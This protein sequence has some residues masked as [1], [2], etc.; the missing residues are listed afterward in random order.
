MDPKKTGNRAGN[1]ERSHSM[2]KLVF[3]ALAVVVMAGCAV[4]DYPVIFDSRGA[5]G[6][7][8]LQSFY[9]KAYIIPTSSVATIW[10]DG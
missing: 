8:V 4:T 1:R 6:D 5:D 3:A 2:R 10:D 9:D 7:G